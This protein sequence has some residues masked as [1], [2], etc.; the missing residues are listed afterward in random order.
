MNHF[1]ILA[2]FGISSENTPEQNME[3]LRCSWSNRPEEVDRR[4]RLLR[5]MRAQSME[6]SELNVE[7][8]YTCR[9]P[10][11]VPDGTPTPEPID[12]IRVYQPSTGPGVVTPCV[13]R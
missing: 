12:D 13:D 7:Y 9:S 4:A 6:F 5:T 8:G 10:A 3:R 11:V 1:A 2:E